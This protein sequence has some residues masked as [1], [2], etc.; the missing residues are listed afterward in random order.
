MSVEPNDDEAPVPESRKSVT[1]ES[2]VQE[3]Q[4]RDA[5]T[6]KR[7][8]R[9]SLRRQLQDVID[10]LGKASKD[11]HQKPAKKIDAL[12]RQ[13]EVL[14]RL[15]EMD[16]DDRDQTLQ[17]EHAALTAQHA[18]DTQRIQEL[19]AQSAELK[20][21]ANRVERIVVT[22]PE[23]ERIRQQNEILGAALSFL[24]TQVLNREQTAIRAIRQL[25]ADAASLVCEAVGI[26]DR[27]YRHYLQT[28]RSERD[29]LNVIEK[30]Q[31]DDT[32]LLRF[33]RAA[34]AVNHSLNL[35]APRKSTGTQTDR[36][37][38]VETLTGEEKL[39]CAK[40]ETGTLNPVDAV[41]GDF[42]PCVRK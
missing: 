22:D 10:Q 21:Q 28:Y 5:A 35:A 31:V 36:P 38:N 24:S 6:E 42:R 32:P 9:K 15:Q 37:A 2:S 7:Y 20:R 41:I 16:A 33:V 11:P 29:L 18:A 39:R 12:L 19:E 30:A 34:L 27:E 13:S 23:H 17:D 8:R 14:L 40:M 4:E 26:K 3:S 25:S 1:D